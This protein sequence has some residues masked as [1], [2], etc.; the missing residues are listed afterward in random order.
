MEKNWNDIKVGDNVIYINPKSES[1]GG[2]T[3][4]G[5]VKKVIT[6]EDITNNKLYISWGKDRNRNPEFDDYS[7]SSYRLDG[8]NTLADQ[9]APHIHAYDDEKSLMAIMLKY[10]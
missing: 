10:T 8:S 1:E 7:F 5:L 4:L 3:V 6:D 9:Y 2:G